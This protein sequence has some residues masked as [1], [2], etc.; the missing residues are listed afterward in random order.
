MIGA[1]RT[2][3]SEPATTLAVAKHIYAIYGLGVMQEGLPRKA[4]NRLSLDALLEQASGL[5]RLGRLHEAE[6][7][8]LS[9][10]AR[11]P[12]QFDALH[13]VGVIRGCQGR[14]D[15]A[16]RLIR[17]A[18]SR[19]PRS[20]TAHNDLGNIL[21]ALQR[22]VD[23]VKSFERAI[24]EDPGFASAHNHLGLAF[25]AVGD[26]EQA[27]A[28]YQKAAAIDQTYAD[29][30]ANMAAVLIRRGQ[31]AEARREYEQAARL[32]PENPDILIELAQLKRFRKDDPHLEAMER[33]L[34]LPDRLAVEHRIGL[35]FSLAKAYADVAEHEAA[36]RQM[37]AGN[38]LQRRHAHYDEAGTLN[39][40]RQAEELFTTALME[41]LSGCGNRSDAPIFIVGMP[42]SGTTLIEQVLASHPAVFGAGELSHLAEAVDRLPSQMGSGLRFPEFAPAMTGEWVRRLG[43]DYVQ[44]LERESAGARRITDKMPHN[45]RFVGLIRLALPNARIIHA[46]RDPVDTCLSCYSIWFRERQMFTYDLAELG[47]LYRAYD[48]LMG[49]WRRVLPPGAMIEVDYEALVGN[50]E[51]EARRIVAYCGLEWHPACLDFHKTERPVLTASISQVREPLYHS[52]V[53]RWRPYE[54]MLQPLLKEL[55]EL[56]EAARSG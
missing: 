19:N 21:R 16:A 47:R 50:F 41:R 55:G 31:L 39:E 56:G 25:D 28:C 49:H 48:R 18:L 8:Y 5:E 17:R 11:D 53:G 46:R 20:A 36:A 27:I 34:E 43:D 6:G 40:L 24:A 23:A 3:A 35:H 37:V 22:P 52:S 12:D 42:R 7:L 13:R 54:R 33:L 14:L 26:T 29:P 10:L 9:I 1:R 32:S 2:P 44:A 45:F 4:G 38:S 30:H 15:D 51:E